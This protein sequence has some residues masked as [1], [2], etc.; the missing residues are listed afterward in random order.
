[1]G[2]FIY[3]PNS[4]FVGYDEFTY[5]AFDGEDYSQDVVVSITVFATTPGS[6]KPVI[7]FLD[8]SGNA[9]LEPEEVFAGDPDDPAI[10]NIE[11]DR[12]NFTCEDL[13]EPVQVNLIIHYTDGS[14]S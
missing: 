2:S 12:E 13:G 14:S 11:L 10:V 7:V 3:T 9:T 8:A 1:Y 4:G 5:A 6:C